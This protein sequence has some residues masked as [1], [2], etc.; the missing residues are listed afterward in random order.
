ME[1]TIEEVTV[2]RS[3]YDDYDQFRRHLADF[4]N[5]YNYA[6]PEDTERLTPFE[7]V[8]KIWTEEPKRFRLDSTHQTPG[9]NTC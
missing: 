3:Q 8:C 2:R 5:A 7:Y 9:L 6:P 1:Q 4:V